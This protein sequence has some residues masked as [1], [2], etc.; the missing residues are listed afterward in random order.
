MKARHAAALALSLTVAAVAVARGNGLATDLA[1]CPD[2][3]SADY[4]FALD[5]ADRFLGAWSF[6]EQDKGLALISQSL[7]KRVGDEPLRDY[8]SGI[9]N[10]THTAFTVGC[11]KQNHKGAQSFEFPA[12]LYEYYNGDPT[13]AGVRIQS[14]LDEQKTAARTPRGGALRSCRRILIL[15]RRIKPLAL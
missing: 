3:P 11:G 2:A 4:L 8:I 14:K 15:H 6:R 5:V 10:P 7:R 9:S 13:G 1:P 12:I